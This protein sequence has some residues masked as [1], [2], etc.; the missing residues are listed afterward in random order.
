MKKGSTRVSLVAWL[1][2]F[3][4]A[5]TA[6]SAA[7]FTASAWGYY[8]KNGINYRNQ[9]YLTYVS[10]G[11]AAAG[12]AAGPT[13]KAAPA[14]WIGVNGR[15]YKSSGSL[16]CESGFHYS[17]SSTAV[18]AVFSKTSCSRKPGTWQSYGVSKAWNGSTYNNYFT[19]K[20]PFYSN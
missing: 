20:S 3:M 12:T 10:P 18:N 14:G 16:V 4:I 8:S 15:L 6:G 2:V 7:A 13:N 5:F 11:P 17:S 1:A 19:F 9:A